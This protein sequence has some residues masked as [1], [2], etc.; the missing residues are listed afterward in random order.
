MHRH[1]SLT[2]LKL[3][4]KLKMEMRDIYFNKFIFKS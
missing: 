2:I 1:M 3:F 4:Q